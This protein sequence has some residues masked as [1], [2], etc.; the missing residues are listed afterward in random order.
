VWGLRVWGFGDGD[1]IEGGF[2]YF[3]RE[4]SVS[5][6]GGVDYGRGSYRDCV[7]ICRGICSGMD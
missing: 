4:E 2:W 5:F 6:R 7:R 3:G 1:I